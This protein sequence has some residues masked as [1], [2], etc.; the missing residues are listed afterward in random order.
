[1]ESII[2]I[3]SEQGFSETWVPADVAT[4]PPTQK[5]LDFI[6]PGNTGTY[7]LGK[8]WINVNAEVIPAPNVNEPA[9]TLN[10]ALYNND[11]VMDTDGYRC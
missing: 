1:M 6:I 2:K 7:D 11:I 3:A 8:C 5:L 10:S 9:N 4:A